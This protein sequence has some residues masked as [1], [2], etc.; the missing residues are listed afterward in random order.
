MSLSLHHRIPP[1]LRALL[2]Q[3]LA[4]FDETRRDGLFAEATRLA[5]RDDVGIIPLYWQKHSWA[6]KAGL[7]YETNVQDDNAI[8]FVHPG[9]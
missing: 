6:T 4:E 7:R 3:G 8:R 9:E 2:A 5:V 1:I